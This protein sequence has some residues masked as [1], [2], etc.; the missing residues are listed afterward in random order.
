M[1]WP[2]QLLRNAVFSLQNDANSASSPMHLQ[3]KWLSPW[4][5]LSVLCG[6]PRRGGNWRF[7][8][9]MAPRERTAAFSLAWP[10]RALDYGCALGYGYS[11]GHGRELLRLKQRNQ[12]QP[13][14]RPPRSRQRMVLPLGSSRQLLRQPPQASPFSR[15]RCLRN[16]YETSTR[17]ARDKRSWRI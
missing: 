15:R 10:Q 16:S 2:W 14:R 7:Y 13:L 3:E 12:P 11:R 4:T 6:F 1:L 17:T 8:Y 9:D 5:H